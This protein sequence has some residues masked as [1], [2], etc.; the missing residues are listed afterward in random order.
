M[1]SITL[2]DTLKKYEK[3]IAT[4]YNKNLNKL[5]K[6]YLSSFDKRLYYN[7]IARKLYSSCSDKIFH[8]GYNRFKLELI[9][10]STEVRSYM[11]LDFKQDEFLVGIGIQVVIT[12]DGD[13]ASI[14]KPLGEDI[15]IVRYRDIVDEIPRV[16]LDKEYEA[17][18]DN[19]TIDIKAR[20][21]RLDSN[22][23]LRQPLSNS[24]L[25]EARFAEDVF[26]LE[27]FLRNLLVNSDNCNYFDKIKH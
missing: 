10:N 6:E 24:L 27:E 22:T 11:Y 18:L 9:K 16:F 26:Q 7:K 19:H 3:I 12:L 8:I 23:E 21:H 2:F 14:E 4:R 25:K 17:I 5:D 15:L 1:N 13:T 20:L